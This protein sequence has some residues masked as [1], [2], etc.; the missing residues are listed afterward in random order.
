VCHVLSNMSGLQWE[1]SEYVCF[2]V[3]AVGSKVGN[4]LLQDAHP[5]MQVPFVLLQE[6]LRHTPV[7]SLRLGMLP[8]GACACALLLLHHILTPL[9]ALAFACAAAPAVPQ[10][11]TQLELWRHG[12]I[13]W[14]SDNVWR[15]CAHLHH[16]SPAFRRLMR[17]GEQ[18][19][20][21][22]NG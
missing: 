6:A 12:Y 14:C 17:P 15:M 8:A 3:T 5:N 13:F 4:A 9:V 16:P 20:L 7:C 18:H 1:A 22:V 21:Q 10:R 19:T 11:S 2:T